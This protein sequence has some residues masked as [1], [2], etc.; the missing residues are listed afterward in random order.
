ML[1]EIADARH[2]LVQISAALQDH[3]L[4]MEVRDNGNGLANDYD[5]RIG[6][7]NTRSRLEQLYGKDHRFTLESTAAS[8]VAATVVIPAVPA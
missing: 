3:H 1:S 7:A 2:G 4:R 6:L 8:G 5:E